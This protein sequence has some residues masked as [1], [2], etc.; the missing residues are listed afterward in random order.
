MELPSFTPI[1]AAARELAKGFI[2]TYAYK[3]PKLIQGAGDKMNTSLKAFCCHTEQAI[4]SIMKQNPRWTWR[5]W[6]LKIL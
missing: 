4:P 1:S 3:S 2:P 5:K 6:E